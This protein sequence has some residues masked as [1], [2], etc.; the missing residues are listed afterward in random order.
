MNLFDSLK[1]HEMT[2]RVMSSTSIHVVNKID[3][4]TIKS[5]DWRAD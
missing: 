2:S 3:G 1:K 4:K 5:I